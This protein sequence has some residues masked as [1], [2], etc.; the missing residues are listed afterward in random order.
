MASSA[1]KEP[2]TPG[3]PLHAR[4]QLLR[5]VYV[6]G[7]TLWWEDPPPGSTP[8]PYPQEESSDVPL[9]PDGPRPAARLTGLS[10]SLTRGCVG[11]PIQGRRQHPSFS[12]RCPSWQG[13]SQH[14]GRIV[15]PTLTG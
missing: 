13:W 5:E 10:L 14:P 3:R 2:R 9:H 8:T 15:M 4:C 1:Q 12:H 11:G 7:S 6:P